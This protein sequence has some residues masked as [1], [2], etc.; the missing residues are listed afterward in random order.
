MASA[1]QT[2]PAAQSTP[3]T[4]QAPDVIPT[5]RYRD[6]LGAIDWLERA[7]GFER[8][9]VYAEGNDVHHAQLRF[10][11]GMIMLGSTRQ[12]GE[13]PVTTPAD[14]GGINTGGIYVIVEDSDAHYARAKAA[15]AEIVRAPTDQDYGSRDYSAR[16]PEGH[17]WSFG[18]YR[19]TGDGA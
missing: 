4:W 15:G 11:S 14:A 16:D 6:A 2:A 3:T 19:P 9:A 7:F 13:W 8:H 17:L 5:V 12:S 10:G 1:T 18:T